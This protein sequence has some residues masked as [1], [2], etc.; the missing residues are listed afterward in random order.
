MR[1][2]S[3]K[4][5]FEV[6]KLLNESPTHGYDLYLILEEQGV[7]EQSS[8][9]YKILRSM[10]EHQ[11]IEESEEDSEIGPNKKILSLTEKGKNQYYARIIE[12]ARDFFKLIVEANIKALAKL[13]RQYLEQFGFSASSLAGK[14][15]FFPNYQG[16][17]EFVL[18]LIRNIFIPYDVELDISVRTIKG[19]HSNLISS[20]ER[21]KVNLRTIDEDLYLRDSTIDIINVL[22]LN[23]KLNT[24]IQS[25]L[26][27]LI[28]MLKPNGAL[29]IF[30]RNQEEGSQR[31]KLLMEILREIL[32]R[33]SA[34]DRARLF[35]HHMNPSFPLSPIDK[36]EL[37]TYLQTQFNTMEFVHENVFFDLF[38]AQGT[39][40]T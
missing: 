13:Y 16:N 14:K 35:P 2:K 29:F 33:I 30:I 19:Q 36:D 6:L 28:K 17:L 21:T 25:R 18:R 39:L 9:L 23:F 24:S 37:H 31:R 11:L 1:S 32:G 3:D 26:G 15:I 8:Y 4:I 7:V 10:K 40:K 34:Q 5:R 27:S 20:F 22:G 38:F 12:S